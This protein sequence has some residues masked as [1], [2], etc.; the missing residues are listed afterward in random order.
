MRNYWDKNTLV[1]IKLIDRSASLATVI[2][3]VQSMIRWP[4]NI[5]VYEAKPFAD[6]L[7]AG[8]E[9]HPPLDKLKLP[10]PLYGT[11]EIHEQMGIC[12]IDVVVEESDFEKDR[13]IQQGYWELC[14]KGAEGDAQAAIEYCKAEMAN[15][16][17]HGGVA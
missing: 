15:K 13:K 4:E 11:L 14:K 2:K 6:I 10:N 7:K 16:V 9:W 3:W 17:N 1:S 8:G 12:W 5:S